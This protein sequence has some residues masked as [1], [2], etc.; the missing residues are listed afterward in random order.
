MSLKKRIIRIV[1]I[2]GCAWLLF[3]FVLIPLKIRGQSME[4]TYHDGGFTFCWRQRFL[5]S[6]VKRGDVVAIRFAGRHVMLLKRVVALA[7]DTVGFR[8]GILYVNGSRVDEPYIRFRSN[9]NLPPRTVEPGRVYVV[10]DNRGVPMQRHHFGQVDA[11]RIM[12]G[13]L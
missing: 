5:F 2:A 6:P 8:N 12:G 1:V 11:Q 4:P 13:V 9:W 7:G 3:S 10:G